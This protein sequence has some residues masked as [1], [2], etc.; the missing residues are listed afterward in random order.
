MIGRGYESRDLAAGSSRNASPT[1][2]PD[3][4]PPPPSF[5]H[6]SP[7]DP[8]YILR[9][10]PSSSPARSPRHPATPVL[11]SRLVSWY[12]TLHFSS[13][14]RAHP[15]PPWHRRR[16][17]SPA[18]TTTFLCTLHRADTLGVLNGI[19]ATLLLATSKCRR[20]RLRRRRRHRSAVPSLITFLPRSLSLS[21][22][23]RLVSFQPTVS[24]NGNAIPST[25]YSHF[26]H[27]MMLND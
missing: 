8:L 13:T 11:A 24:G 4:H 22:F 17:R 15:A 20:R 25:E 7:P 10:P 12:P 14:L 27:S 3:H 19:V 5:C 21:L 6:G 16:A 23:H 26:L 1:N 9:L 18:A 2:H